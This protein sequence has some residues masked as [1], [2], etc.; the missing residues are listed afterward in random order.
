MFIF[1]FLD[2]FIGRKTNWCCT[3]CVDCFRRRAH[4]VIDSFIHFSNFPLFVGFQY[5]S[6]NINL[7]ININ[8]VSVFNTWNTWI[9]IFNTCQMFET[10]NWRKLFW[11]LFQRKT[12]VVKSQYLHQHLFFISYVLIISL[13]LFIG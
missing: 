13:L 9:M 3:R 4:C 1:C 8:S 7:N 10:W 5:Q 6:F 11:L 2:I 12:V